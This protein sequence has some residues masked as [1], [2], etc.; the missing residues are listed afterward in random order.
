MLSVFANVARVALPAA[1][2]PL[3]LIIVPTIV[4]VLVNRKIDISIS[5]K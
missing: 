5:L 3:G 4:Y 1:V 2:G